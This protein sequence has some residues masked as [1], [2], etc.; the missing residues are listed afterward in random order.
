PMAK[1]LPLLR[2]ATDDD[3]QALAGLIALTWAAYPGTVLDVAGEEPWLLAPRTSYDAAGGR[4]WV[5]TVSSSVVGCGGVRP[6]GS[7]AEL[8][9]LYVAA[10]HRRVGIASRL[11]DVIERTARSWGA[12]RV[13]LWSDTR[14]VEAHAFYA[15][16]GYVASDATREL[17]DRSAT[18]E[19]EFVKRL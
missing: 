7:D 3:A 4:L 17:H 19:R 12:A 5:A 6:R 15:R 10:A 14:F 2:E 18:V 11:V 13:G 8:K 9:S 1:P 16:R